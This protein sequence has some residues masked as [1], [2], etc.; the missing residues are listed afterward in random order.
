M[1]VL[2]NSRKLG[3]G[4]QVSFRVVEDRDP[5]IPLVITDSGEMEVPYIGRI[6]A[7]NRTCKE[8]AFGIKSALEVDYYYRATVIIGL[9]RV[10]V[11]SKGRVYVSG[12]VATKG[13]ID[14]PAN[15]TFTASNAI[16]RAGGFERFANKRKIRIIRKL[17]TGGTDIIIFDY[18]KTI[19]EGHTENDVLLQPGDI[20]NVPAKVI[21]L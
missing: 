1:A 15:E 9:D 14:I 11:E 13:P 2:D 4:D 8:L 21:N 5:P 18:V 7:S 10:N 6:K 3:V 17:P 20:I 19:E 12:E 16:T